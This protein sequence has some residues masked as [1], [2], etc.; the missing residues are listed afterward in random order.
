MQ[1]LLQRWRKPVICFNLIDKAGVAAYVRTIE[2]I[3]KC[4]SRRLR[5]I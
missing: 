3:E 4:G 5:L 1:A 2:D